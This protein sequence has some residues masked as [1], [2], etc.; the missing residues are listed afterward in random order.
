[1]RRQWFAI[2]WDCCLGAGGEGEVFLGRSLH[3]GKLCAV[4]VSTSLDAS[5][6]REHLSVELERYLR[7]AGDGVVGLVAWNLDAPRPF[8]VF[9]L[10]QTGTLADEMRELR[11]QGR[12]Y[13]PVRA[14]RRARAVLE[15]LERVHERGLLHRDVKPANLLRFGEQ[16][17]LTDF[18][19]GRSM[20]R[21]AFHTET[22]VGTRMYSAPEQREGAPTDVRA[23]LY[24][25]GCILYEM[26]TGA[27]P[28]PAEEPALPAARH[29]VLFL[30]E[31]ERLL[32]S[33]LSPKRARR[34]VDACD[35]IARV[36]EV[37][38]AYG[39]TRRAWEKLRLGPSPY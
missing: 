27:A 24:S 10:A 2:D 5:E 36:D 11:Q 39:R 30:P 14:L 7:A 12:V 35:A 3:T 13:H 38:D 25:V 22:L 4:K 31:L 32:A 1:M 34:P 17:K 15:A 6:A 28:D 37:L 26:L 16:L 33:L 20:A 21:K 8:L 19:A 18:G 23:D 9:E 29:D